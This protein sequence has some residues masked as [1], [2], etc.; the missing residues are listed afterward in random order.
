MRTIAG[1]GRIA[2]SLDFGVEG[3]AI[4]LPFGGRAYDLRARSLQLDGLQPMR[5]CEIFRSEVRGRMPLEFVVRIES[6]GEDVGGCDDRQGLVCKDDHGNE[7]L[8]GANQLLGAGAN[9]T[10]ALDG[11]G[12]LREV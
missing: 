11:A 1:F 9:F 7:Q 6:A 4:F 8:L 12:N 10:A 5:G 3:F 2:V